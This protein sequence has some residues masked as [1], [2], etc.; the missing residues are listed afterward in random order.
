MNNVQNKKLAFGCMRLP[1]KNDDIDYDEFKKM[2][3]MFIE[4]GFTY[5]DTAHG[6]HGGKSELAIKE[7]LTSRYPRE[8]YTL[9]DK[10]TS[11]YFKKEEDIIP[12][13]FNQLAWCGVDYFDYYLMHAQSSRNY[14]HF[15]DNHAYEVC[16]KLKE[17]GYIKYLGISFHDNAEF[18]DKILTEHPEIEIV[19]IQFNY[20]DYLS[21][22]VQSKACYDVV[23]SHNLPVLIMEPVKGGKLANLN[24]K[25]AKVLNDLNNGTPASYAVRFAASHEGVYQ[26][27]SGMSNLAQVDDNTSYMQNFIPLND[28]EYKA[29]NQV[30]EVLNELDLIECTACR[31]CVEGCPKQIRIPDLFN[32][33]NQYI[34]FNNTGSDFSF[35][36]ATRNGG[37][38][39]SCIKCGK[40]ENICPQHLPIRNELEKIS[41]IFEKN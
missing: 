41:K 3:D 28:K 33:Y 30:V 34:Q 17:Q 10:L 2:V 24:E 11:E 14:Q 32:V 37:L 1:L 21:S 26:V 23:R 20:F 31:Y 12:F 13:F 25:A 8:A 22:L 36:M 35:S 4:R 9:T 6:Y 27:L 5:F 39:S 7:C 15:M 19:Q 38:P 40:C 29:I 16:K 18:L